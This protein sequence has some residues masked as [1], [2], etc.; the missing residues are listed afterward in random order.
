[1]AAA[2]IC[3][4]N[5]TELSRLIAA[6]DLSSSEVVSATLAHLERL[7]DKLNAFITV[8]P[9]P[10]LAA[11]K[12]ADEDIT[13]GQNRGPLHGVPVKSRICLRPLACAPREVQKFWPTGSRKRT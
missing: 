9:E 1:M 13:R 2:D 10:S 7:E 3:E 6:R 4:L 5:L 8:L 12:K 11:A